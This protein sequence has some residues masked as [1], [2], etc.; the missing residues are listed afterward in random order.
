[1][2]NF[3]SRQS[4]TGFDE[5]AIRRNAA[6]LRAKFLR[7]MFAHGWSR[8]SQKRTAAAAQPKSAAHA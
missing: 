7:Q 1:M 6:N 8:L 4:V 2:S 3:Q 5:Q